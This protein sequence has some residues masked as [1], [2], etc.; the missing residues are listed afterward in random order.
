MPP[1]G[2]TGSLEGRLTDTHSIPLVFAEILLRN[3]DT[4]AIFHAVTG[5][6]G[7]Y[8]FTALPPGEYRLEADLPELGHG[9]VEEIL[10]SAGHASRVQAALRM[11]LPAPTPLQYTQ[12]TPDPVAPAVTTTISLEELSS[13]PLPTSGAGRDWQAIAASLPSAAPVSQQTRPNHASAVPQTIEELPDQSLAVAGITTQLESTAIDGISELPAFHSQ[14]GRRGTPS[15]AG[16]AML[17]PSAIESIRGRIAAG[18][19]ESGPGI[20]GGIGYRTARG[21]NG[22]HGQAFYLNRESLWGAENPFTQWIQQTAPADGINI[23][24]FTPE[25]WS[26]ANSQQTFGLG[27]G[28]QLRRNKLWWFTALDGQLRS[29][30]AVATVRHPDEFYAQPTNDELQV[31]AARLDLPEPAVLE[32]GAKAYSDALAGLTTLLGPVPRRSDEW[33]G[34]GRVDWQPS[35]RQHINLEAGY[36][37]V[38]ATAGAIHATSA[39]YGSHSFGNSQSAGLWQLAQWQSF[40]TP[41]LLNSFAGEFRT[42]ALSDTPQTPSAFEA[43]LLANSLNQLPEIVADSKYGFILG[44]PARLTGS[45]Y[46]FESLIAASESVSWVLG[47]HLIRGGATFDHS[48]DSTHSLLNQ[49]GTYSYT[50]VLNFISDRAS[51]L[52][53]GLNAIGNPTSEQHNCDVTGRVHTVDGAILGLGT[54]PCYAWFS[55]TVGPANWHIGSNNLAAYGTDQWQPSHNFTLSAGIRLES[56]QLPPPIAFADNPALPQTE[57][58]PK[59]GVAIAPRVGLAWQPHSGTVLRLGGGLYYGRIDNTT[60]LAALSQTGSLAGDLN[61]FF[62]PT[63]VGAPPFPYAFSAPPANAIEPGATAFAPHFKRQEVDQAVFSIEQQLPDHWI[64]N[65]SAMASLGRRLPI[66]ID[67]NLE[68]ALGTN[69]QPQTITY[70][71]V[72]S[73]DGG[74]LKSP[75]IT[76]PLYTERPDADYQQIS[77]LF[78]RANS[79]YEAAMIRLI[80]YGGNG[81]DLHAHYIYA[82]AADWNPN[83]SAQLAG[84]DVLDPEDFSLEYGTSNLDIRSSAGLTLLYRAPWKLKHWQGALA[85]GWGAGGIGNYHSG[86][87][88]TMR[89]GGYVPSYYAGSALIEGVGPGVNGSGGDNRLYEIGRNTYR[90]PATWTGNVR[91]SRRFDLHNN[92]ELEV[93]AESFNLFNHQNVTL[94]ETT[95]YYI[96]RG[97]TNGSDA[98]LNFMTGLE[99]NGTPSLTTV[100]FGKPLN[101]NATD[102]FRPR[103][104]QLGLRARF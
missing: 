26:P 67:T 58:L 76:E 34:F 51:F 24:Q 3:L 99:A 74:P 90:Y 46:P 20:A 15:E 53:Y 27:I 89:V 1:A 66:S 5:K 91:L 82:H 47:K 52:A 28:S 44:T 43:P 65:V 55:Q 73:I 21:H 85:N 103:E 8:R 88:F 10:V 14:S 41:N 63:D 96:Y 93:L 50:D 29:D 69:G 92:R 36:S 11:E 72:D 7:S 37:R 102:F 83:E 48:N 77:T 30:P 13:L 59:L 2:A 56:E 87:P 70:S 18:P 22:L 60:L 81:L 79:T 42:V 101:V 104:I 39:T 54:L 9:S 64:V 38:D 75:T 80:R 23:A 45:R 68:R 12:E 16:S 97:G 4:G 32:E 25:Q 17:G 94:L 6:N 19:A 84:S 98:T 62:K 61:Y 86:L 71:V 40:L 49:A 100:E 57:A 31:L 35:D 78:S 95:G 33:E